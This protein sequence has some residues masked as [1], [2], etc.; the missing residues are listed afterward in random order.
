MCEICIKVFIAVLLGGCAFD[1]GLALM[2]M[3]LEMYFTLQI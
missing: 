2:F 3:G 1:Y